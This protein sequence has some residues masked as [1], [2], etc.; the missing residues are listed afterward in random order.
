[1]KSED[2]LKYKQ[3]LMDKNVTYDRVGDFTSKFFPK[4][5]YRYRR[6][7]EYWREDLFM[8]K[9]HMSKSS[10]LNDPYEGLVYV[11]NKAFLNATIDEFGDLS[12]ELKKGII[13]DINL[14]ENIAEMQELVR[15]ASFTEVKDSI[16][17]WGHYSDSHKGFCIEYDFTRTDMICQKYILPVIYSN[18]RYDAT[19][20]ILEYKTNNYANPFLF[21][22]SIWS[23][24]KEWRLLWTTEKK[25]ERDCNFDLSKLI[26][27]VY[28]GVNMLNQ[29]HGME[30]L[31]EIK[32]WAIDNNINV[33]Q[34]KIEEYG[35]KIYPE[36]I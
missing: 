21:K 11:D 25:T 32:E 18:R 31:N 17:M 12:E 4:P 15:V 10:T 1:M 16:L 6:F 9:V 26:T 29:D 23:Y 22:N 13:K 8:G 34:M 28:L 27:G 36:K 33:Y 2:V 24:E 3:L 20:D 14:D 19:D 30:H 7:G 35:Y 5:I